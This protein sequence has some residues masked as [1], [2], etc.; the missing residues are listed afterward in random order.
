[1]FSLLLSVTVTPSNKSYVDACSLGIVN[2]PEIVISGIFVSWIITVWVTIVFK[3]LVLSI[4]LYSTVYVFN[5]DVSIFAISFPLS[6]YVITIS[7][8]IST[9]SLVLAV[10]ADCIYSSL[11]STVTID[12]PPIIID[13]LSSVIC[14]ITLSFSIVYS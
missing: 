13:G 12:S 2:S 9:P 4:T 3:F 7:L 10:A 8:E 14:V 5:W 6:K 1:M 11:T